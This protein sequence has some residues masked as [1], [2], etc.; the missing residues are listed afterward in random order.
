[1]PTLRAAS[2]HGLATFGGF[3]AAGIVPL[4][5]YLSPWFEEFRFLAAASLALMTLF[6]VGASR[7]IFTG[8]GWLISGI[9]MLIIGAL[10][11]CVA[12]GVGAAGA[13]I[14]RQS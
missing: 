4:L 7:S 10:A 8:R 12:Y 9:E 2:G 14:L 13:I 6:A 1:M 5:A 3:L 11:T